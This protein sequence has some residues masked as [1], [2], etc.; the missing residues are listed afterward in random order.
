MSSEPESQSGEKP[1]IGGELIIPAAAI[2]FTLY[3]FY[4]IIGAPWT[5]QVSAFFNGSI[6]LTLCAILIVTTVVKVARR[7]ASLRFDTLIEPI[8]ILPKR[9]FLFLLTLGYIACLDWAG[10]TITTFVFLALAMMLLS[11]RERK[12]KR[13]ILILSGALAIGGYL[14]FVVAFERQFP[15]GPF[16][17]AVTA[18]TKALGGS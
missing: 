17:H 11:G 6:L 12:N 8:G 14:L 2:L 15:E 4:S 3:Y 9:I 5:A 13:L 7:Q 10:F 16:E 1:P 18:V